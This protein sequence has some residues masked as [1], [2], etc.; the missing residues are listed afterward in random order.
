[1]KEQ[2]Y[3]TR[4][5]TYE[6]ISLDANKIKFQKKENKQKKKFKAIIVGLGMLNVIDYL[7]PFGKL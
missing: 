2:E 4:E 3:D 7:L 1:M 5:E 6:K